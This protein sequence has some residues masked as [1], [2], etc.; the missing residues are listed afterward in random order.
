MFTGEKCSPKVGD[1]GAT[2]PLL[3]SGEFLA[4]YDE[5][6]IGFEQMSAGHCHIA[7]NSLWPPTR[8]RL[9]CNLLGSIVTW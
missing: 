8:S 4:S 6:Q 3:M 1:L 9:G 7:K 2:I 5:C